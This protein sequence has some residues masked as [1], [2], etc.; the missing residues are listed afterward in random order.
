MGRSKSL[1]AWPAPAK[2]N[3]FLHVVGRRPD[4]RHE[5]QT[6]FQ[7]LDYGDCLRFRLREDG[8]I[9]ICG[10]VAGENDLAVRAARLLQAAGGTFSGV[11]IALEKRIPVGSG[12]GGGSSDAATVLMALNRLWDIGFDTA[13]LSEI[14]LSL[15]AD[16]PL[17]VC[18]HS[19]WAEGV[20]ERLTPT[21]L[22]DR[23]YC[24][25]VPSV[26]VATDRVFSSTELTR[27]TPRIKIPGR[28]WR[29]LRNDLEPV[30]CA[31]YPEVQHCLEWLRRHGNA[32][33]TGSGGASFLSVGNRQ[34]ALDILNQAPPGCTGFVARGLNRHPLADETNIG[35]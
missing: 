19:A 16:V 7:L 28:F 3:L 14:G 29:G 13:T 25:L 17:F 20:G 9:R 5:L 27:N 6:L 2:L 35:V 21:M 8:V 24:V 12:L 23:W 26:C 34:G 33:M 30:T 32:R 15:G 10:S 4:G 22:E 31:L 18:G 1:K 11:D